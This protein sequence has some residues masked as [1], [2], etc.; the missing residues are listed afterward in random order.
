[1]PEF[2]ASARKDSLLLMQEQAEECIEYQTVGPLVQ[3]DRKT[4]H[5]GA[6]LAEPFPKNEEDEDDG[7][8]TE[9]MMKQCHT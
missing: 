1:M 7:N 4:A 6:N 5:S 9:K 3:P 8:V 2:A